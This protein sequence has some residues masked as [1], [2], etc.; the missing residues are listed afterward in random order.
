MTALRQLADCQV[1]YEGVFTD[2]QLDHPEGIAIAP[3][4]AV[5]C[6]GERGQ[7]FRIEADGSDIVEVASTGGLC[8][9]LT[10]HP[11]GR[12][13][14]ICDAKRRAVFRLD[15]RTGVLLSFTTGTEERPFGMPN[16]SAFDAQGRLYVTD[17]AP[18]D[19]PGPGI[20]RVETDGST[21]LWHSGPLAS[22]NGIAV[23]PEDGAIYVVETWGRR[24]T[25]VAVDES[26]D[27]GAMT[28]VAATGGVPDGIAF[29]PDGLLYVACYEPSQVA[30]IERDGRYQ[31][32]VADPDA[33]MLCH[34]TNVA[35]RDGT[36]FVPNLGRWHVTALDLPTD[37]E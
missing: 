24:I 2:P 3:D 20:Y 37:P 23:G 19:R 29:G 32:V 16:A 18:F 7:I 35:F 22:A 25:R 34:P 5:W 6:G 10:F 14:M 12:S 33:H 31:V 30:R 1:F 36:L 27:P 8:L 21:M 13:L 15:T 11:D 26:G 28:L 9:G 17:T 4:G